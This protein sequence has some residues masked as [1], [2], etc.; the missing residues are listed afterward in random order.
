MHR[1][2]LYFTERAPTRH[3]SIIKDYQVRMQSARCKAGHLPALSRVA[4]TL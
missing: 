4:S 2:F 1:A 3:F